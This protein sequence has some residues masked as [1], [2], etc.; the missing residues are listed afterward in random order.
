MGW[1]WLDRSDQRWNLLL[2]VVD[3]LDPERIKHLVLDLLNFAWLWVFSYCFPFNSSSCCRSEHY[4]VICV[5]LTFE[6]SCSI[7]IWVLLCSI[8][9]YA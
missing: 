8:C 7:L 2:F 5:F 4:P 6:S 1:I 9:V 3:G